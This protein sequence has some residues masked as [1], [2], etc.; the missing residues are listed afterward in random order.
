[1]EPYLVEVPD[2]SS[3]GEIRKAFA[4]EHRLDKMD[5]EE[6]QVFE[7]EPLAA[8]RL[9]QAEWQQT[10][11]DDQLFEQNLHKAIVFAA[12]AKGGP[13]KLECLEEE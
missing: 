6:A 12:F 2:G 5:L 9:K 3:I 10:Y 8:E 1:M 4:K 11:R 13:V 7:L